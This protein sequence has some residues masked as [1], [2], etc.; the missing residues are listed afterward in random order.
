M[1]AVLSQRLPL[2]INSTTYIPLPPGQVEKEQEQISNH[3][4]VCMSIG[5]GI[6][7]IR[8]IA[9][10]EPILSEAAS[11]IMSDCKS[12][13]LADVLA[14][15]LSGFGINPGDRAELLV[16]AFF[17]WARDK[18][19][20]ARHDP[21]CPGQ[22]SRY[23]SVTDLFS[24]LFSESTYAS[25]SRAIPSLCPP[26]SKFKRQTFEKTF[27]NALMHY[28][29]FIKAHEQKVLKR[30]HL[31]A[32]MARGAAAFGANCQPGFDILYPFLFGGDTVLSVKKLGL[33]I[34]QIKKN[35][36]KSRKARARVFKKMDPYACGLLDLDHID[37]DDLFPIL[38]IRIVFALCSDEPGVTIQA[39]S[40]PLEGA[41]YLDCNGHPRFI[42][43]DFWCLGVN[44][45]IL[46]PVKEAPDRWTALA[47]KADSW[48]DFYN[49]PLDPGLLRS[50]NPGAAHDHHHFDSWSA[51]IPGFEDIF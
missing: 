36:L 46:Q 10:S 19:V 42:S 17:T 31:L 18:T 27:S 39:Y 43:Y 3:I 24:S 9:A 48:K 30:P 22:L 35:D 47:N 26:N 32:F 37:E 25:M 51:P 13:H 23:F 5:D 7:T 6:E 15:V 14:E 12:F 44:P 49:T 40:S 16:S 4:C 29:H 45:D 38:I 34:S 28:N 21:Q 2:D 11:L 20:S 50:L 33:A 41:S 8:G 1:Y